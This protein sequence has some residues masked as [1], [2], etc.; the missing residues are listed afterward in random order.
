M[1]VKEQLTDLLGE[2]PV[3]VTLVAVSKTCP[4][5]Q[6]MEAYGEGVRAFGESRPQEL[7]A[8]HEELPKEIK[9]HM[10]GNLQTNKV[11]YIAPFVSLIHSVDSHKLLE[12]INKEAW[13]NGRIIDVLFEV[14]IAD[15]QSKSGWEPGALTAYIEGGE[16]KTL[17]NV[18][19]R[20]LMGIAT[21]TD[22]E[23]QIRG[24][25][26][27]LHDMFTE[28][29][30]NHFGKDFDTLSMGMTSDWKIAVECGATMVRI[31]SLIF[32]TRESKK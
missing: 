1:G 16:Y 20:G 9:W 31:G 5:A 2:I 12:A 30:A 8:K 27:R 29:K 11:K 18:R 6:I 13:K 25:F 24:E 28:L 10:I 14:H 23:A 15:E 4:A 3:G 19:I 21:L 22:D 17:S 26:T 32:G 7:K